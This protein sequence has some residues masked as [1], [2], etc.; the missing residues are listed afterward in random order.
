[1]AQPEVPAGASCFE[2]EEPM[3]TL[4]ALLSCAVLAGAAAPASAHDE[5][6]TIVY[7]KK[8]MYV[9]E[10]SDVPRAR[11]AYV[12]REYVV[13]EYMEN[14]TTTLPYGSGSWWRQMDREQ[15]GGG[16]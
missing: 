7:V 13:P 1:M 2:M 3:K 5:E 9:D 8:Y 15:R 14:D 16:S 10:D 4:A 12:V 6:Y 11:P